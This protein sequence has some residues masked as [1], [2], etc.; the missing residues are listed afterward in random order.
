MA[1]LKSAL[2]SD[3]ERVTLSSSRPLCEVLISAV[4]RT[5]LADCLYYRSGILALCALRFE[6]ATLNEFWPTVIT[7]FEIAL[8]FYVEEVLLLLFWPSLDELIFWSVQ[9]AIVVDRPLNSFTAM[10]ADL[11]PNIERGFWLILIIRVDEFRA[12]QP[13]L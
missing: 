8:N 7:S 6:R 12:Q 3:L 11:C 9:A 1:S 10:D 13:Q 5:K 2:N 4:M